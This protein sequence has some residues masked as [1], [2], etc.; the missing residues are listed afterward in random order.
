MAGFG[1]ML[2]QNREAGLSC[3]GA[4]DHPA[5]DKGRLYIEL[6]CDNGDVIHVVMR[7]LGPDQGMG[8]GRINE[9]GD[10]ITLFYHPSEDEARRRLKQLQNDIALAMDAQAQQTKN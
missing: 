1:S 9:T 4:M 2:L 3:R 8:V 6:E 5:N 7:N 10:R